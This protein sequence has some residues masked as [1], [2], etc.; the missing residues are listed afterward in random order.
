MGERRAGF[1]ES[2]AL[3]VLLQ[4]EKGVDEINGLSPCHSVLF[5]GL[6][7]RF[8]V[9]DGLSFIERHL[10]GFALLDVG[11]SGEGKNPRPRKP[12]K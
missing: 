2:A 5:Q 10:D 3:A 1:Q 12:G 9:A 6:E 7:K 11:G 4:A 8:T